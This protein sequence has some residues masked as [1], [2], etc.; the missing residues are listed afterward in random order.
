[1]CCLFPEQVGLVTFSSGA[2]IR[3][4]LDDHSNLRSLL[5]ALSQVRYTGK[6]SK[7]K[8][9]PSDNGHLTMNIYPPLIATISRMYPPLIL[10]L[11]CP[12]E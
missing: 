11:T 9:N 1:M 10:W 5:Y 12:F 8:R 6:T 3:F 2:R 7:V 4:D